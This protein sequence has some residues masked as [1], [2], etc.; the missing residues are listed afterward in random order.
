MYYNESE[1]HT[2][3]EVRVGMCTIR[4]GFKVFTKMFCTLPEARPMARGTPGIL[5][6]SLGTVPTEVYD[7]CS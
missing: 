6:Y 3:G 5:L 1:F 4:T 7:L 2:L